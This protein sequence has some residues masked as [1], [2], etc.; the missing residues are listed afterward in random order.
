M[1]FMCK[2]RMLAAAAAVPLAS[3]ATLAQTEAPSLAG[4]SA[5]RSHQ[6]SQ[7]LPLR[8]AQERHDGAC[9]ADAQDKDVEDLAAYYSAIEVT[10]TPPPK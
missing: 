2:G 9:S 3:G 1:S 4:Q 8:R 5:R 6:G 10:V 7:R